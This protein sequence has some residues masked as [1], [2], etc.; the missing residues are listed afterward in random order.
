MS[1]LVAAI[2]LALVAAAPP[3]PAAEADVHKPDAVV[4]WAA[5]RA[6]NAAAGKPEI[7]RFPLAHHGTWGSGFPTYYVAGDLGSGPEPCPC[8][9][10][11]WAA[12]AEEPNTLDETGRDAGRMAVVEGRFTGKSAQVKEYED[13][14]DSAVH[15]VWDFEVLRWR[16]FRDGGADE[17]KA[18]VV[19]T[20]AQASEGVAA[21]ADERPWLAT[22]DSFPALQ[23]GG[24]DKARKLLDKVAKTGFAKAEVIDSRAARLLFCCYKVVVAGR[25]ATQDEATA[26]MKELKKKGFANAGVRRGW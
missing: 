11:Q 19:A 3:P 14:P 2:A 16:P 23:K 1:A 9:A 13:S 18:R 8:I 26:L 24:D 7:V 6:R 5:E 20:S 17:G 25:F 10:P 4:K 21:L 12:G 15:T 22:V